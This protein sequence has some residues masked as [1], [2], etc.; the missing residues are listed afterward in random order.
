MRSP[1]AIPRNWRVSSLSKRSSSFRLRERRI[2]AGGGELGRVSERICLSWGRVHES[3]TWV[4]KVSL[5]WNDLNLS[6]MAS[7]YLPCRQ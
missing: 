6:F 5:D 3:G 4:L 2:E 7:K 1:A